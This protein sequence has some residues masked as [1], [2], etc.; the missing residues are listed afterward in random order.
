M[1]RLPDFSLP[2]HGA[3]TSS[4]E[5]SDFL[6]SSLWFSL[7]FEIRGI[8]GYISVEIVCMICVAVKMP[9]AGNG[10]NFIAPR[11]NAALASCGNGAVLGLS[12]VPSF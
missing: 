1:L 2:P 10:C 4:T 6:R 7:V 11:G 8:C 3:G 9:I 12:V 5:D